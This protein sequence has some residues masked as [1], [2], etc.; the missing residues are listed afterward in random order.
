VRDH[1]PAVA[2]AVA[3]SGTQ[4]CMRSR[5]IHYVEFNENGGFTETVISPE[6]LLN[7]LDSYVMTQLPEIMRPYRELFPKQ[8][9]DFFHPK[10]QA[11]RDSQSF[12][13]TPK[14]RQHMLKEYE[15]SE[16]ELYRKREYIRQ[17]I[18]R[19]LGNDLLPTLDS[20]G[21]IVYRKLWK[22]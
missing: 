12:A 7:S 13:I 21:R 22:K 2:G 9:Y 5:E 10:S 8:T 18:W 17:E 19:E 15:K 11:V 1:R 4:F 16:L 3:D 14:V 20:F 6:K